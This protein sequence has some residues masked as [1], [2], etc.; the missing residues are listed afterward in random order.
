MQDQHWPNISDLTDDNPT[1]WG[2][3]CNGRAS[4]QNKRK[5]LS[6]GINKEK[7]PLFPG[8]L[9]DCRLVVVDI[10][11]CLPVIDIPKKEKGATDNSL[12]S[13]LNTP[14]TRKSKT[15]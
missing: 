14:A 12:N 1:K 4:I 11:H 5:K 13:Q 8:D 7:Q 9:C 10:T 3:A 15:H 2:Q 6:P